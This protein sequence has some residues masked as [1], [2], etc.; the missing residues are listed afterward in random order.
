[1]IMYHKK[2]GIG[3]QREREQTRTENRTNTKI[4]ETEGPNRSQE[5]AGSV[6]HEHGDHKKEQ[7]TK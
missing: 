1:M 6:K 5:A 7:I 3:R 2:K 4:A